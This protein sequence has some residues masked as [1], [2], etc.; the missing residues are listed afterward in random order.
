MDHVSRL[1]A[2]KK[3]KAIV[4]C[5]QL[6]RAHCTSIRQPCTN[7]GHVSG[8]LT[9]SY[10]HLPG[11]SERRIWTQSVLLGTRNLWGNLDLV[12]GCIWLFSEKVTLKKLE[13]SSKSGYRNSELYASQALFLSH[14]DCRHRPCGRF[15]SLASHVI[16]ALLVVIR[17]HLNRLWPMESGGHCSCQVRVHHKCCEIF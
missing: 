14:S 11:E 17:R 5:N 16:W 8:S 13:S 15:L 10:I 6:F 3:K 1:N 4:V 2:V 12:W 7:C 9:C